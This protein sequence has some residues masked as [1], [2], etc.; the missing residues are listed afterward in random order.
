MN[1]FITTKE[2]W[3]TEKNCKDWKKSL[4]RENVGQSSGLSYI[5]LEGVELDL[6]LLEGEL[7][8]P[9]KI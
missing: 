9:I 2:I 7:P 3:K 1:P 4:G 6:T 8:M 5:L